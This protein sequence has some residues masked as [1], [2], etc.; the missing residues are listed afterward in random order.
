MAAVVLLGLLLMYNNN[1]KPALAAPVR[2]VGA[3]NTVVQSSISNYGITTSDPDTYSTFD[4]VL[5][6]LLCYIVVAVSVMGVWHSLLG[7]C[8]MALRGCHGLD[9]S[10]RRSDDCF[11]APLPSTYKLR[12]S[13]AVND[14]LQ[15]S[16]LNNLFFSGPDS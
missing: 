10:S 7:E 14:I 1:S 15:F 11:A 3:S 12:H 8:R 6:H 2:R 13:A 4:L 9:V 5:C 16:R